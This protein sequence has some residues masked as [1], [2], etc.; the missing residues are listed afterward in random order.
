MSEETQSKLE[1]IRM[2]AEIGGYCPWERNALPE[3]LVF[4]PVDV[5]LSIIN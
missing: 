4:A 1:D 2:A 5:D 3:D